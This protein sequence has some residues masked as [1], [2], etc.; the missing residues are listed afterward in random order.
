MSALAI[1]IGTY[2]IKALSGST[3]LTPNIER[4]VE[5][6]NPTGV[7]VP[8]DDALQRKLLDLIEAMIHDHKLPKNDLRLSLP[9]TV[10]STKVIQ[11]PFLSDAELASAIG[12][13]AEQH[14]PIPPDELSLEYYVL[15]RPPKKEQ[16]DE[17]MKVLLVGTRKNMIERYVE[18]F[19][20]MGIEPKLIET[21]ALSVLRSLEIKSDEPATLAV[22]MGASST[23]LIMVY[24]GR[25]EFVTSQMS[26]GQALTKVLEKQIKLTTQQAE[27][28][29][30]AYG[31]SPQEFQGKV[32][33]T[34]L[35]AVEV[36]LNEIKKA[37]TFFSNQSPG[38]NVQRVLLSGG[39]SLL[40][41]LVQIITQEL[42]VEV[43]TAAPFAQAS[44]QI[45]EN[46]QPAWSV[47]MGLLM[48]EEL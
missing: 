14:I 46:N 41:E 30:R 23:Q 20:E 38:V 44:G 40:P 4:A 18:M 15:H 43:L 33:D 21:Q 13:Q 42:G 29:K 48:R 11:L 32:R 10:V 35:P 7:A 28:Y 16:E 47:C 8:S 34:L 5:I 9:E 31:L 45:P 17:K 24:Q 25:L 3:G 1:D 36:L 39:A 27:E 2:T 37:T 26:G 6:F 22:H 12:W 19:V